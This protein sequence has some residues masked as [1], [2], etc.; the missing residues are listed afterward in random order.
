MSRGSGNQNQD[1]PEDELCN[2]GLTPTTC[3]HGGS[4]FDVAGA[5][6]RGLDKTR[7]IICAD[8][9]DAW[10]PPAPR[11]VEVLREHLPWLIRTSPPI[12]AE[13]MVKKIAETRGINPACILP[14]AGSSDLMYLAFLRWLNRSSRALILDPT[15]GEYAHILKN[16]VG[17]RVDRLTLRREAKYALD[18]ALLSACLKNGYDL[19]VLVNPNSPTGHYVPRAE[20]EEVLLRLPPRTRVWI[21]ESY[22]EF[23]GPDASLERFAATHAN[24]IVGKSMSKVYALSGVRAAY[25]CAVRPVI[26]EL[27]AMVPPWSISLPAQLAAVT[28]L[29]CFDYYTQRYRQTRDL[30]GAL[31]A[32]L[33]GR[34]DMQIIPGTANFLLAHLSERGPDAATLVENCRGRGLLV[35]DASNMGCEIGSRAI[36]ITIQDAE[37]N[38]AIAKILTEALLDLNVAKTPSA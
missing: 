7:T 30:R 29:D 27:K 13:G 11:V 22:V 38:Q 12:Y 32:R 19:V 16:V 26:E 8:T 1:L 28:A 37:T 18:I 10:F 5:D 6:F 25:L 33:E 23:V 4:F 36:R 20:L 35:R 21:D 15:Y 34:T 31:T 24:V 2:S 9:L 3:F 14:G 17:C